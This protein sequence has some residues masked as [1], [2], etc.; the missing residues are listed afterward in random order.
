MIDY[1]FYRELLE[2]LINAI[3]TPELGAVVSATEAALAARTDQLEAENADTWSDARNGD[4]PFGQWPGDT[5][6]ARLN[7]AVRVQWHS[8]VE[9]VV[10]A[11][12][13]GDDAEIGRAFAHGRLIEEITG[14]IVEARREWDTR[15]LQADLAE[16]GQIIAED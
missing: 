6:T 16:L 3:G 9:R 5:L 14:Q 12:V 4:L 1:R 15:A 11:V 10:D 8:A 2:R 7:N 13:S